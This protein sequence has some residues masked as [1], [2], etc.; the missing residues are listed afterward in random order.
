MYVVPVLEPLSA[1]GFFSVSRRLEVY[2]VIVFDYID[3]SGEYAQIV[4]DEEKLHRELEILTANM[5]G[6]LDEEEVV[7]NGERVRPRVLS[8]DVGFRG[9]PEEV[10]IAFFIYF[11]GK[12]VKGENYYENIYEE[13]V[14]EYPISAYWLFPPGSRVKS[15]EMSG[16]VALLAPNIV[17][18]KLEE[19][20]RVQGYERI[21]FTL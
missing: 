4:E 3:A 6:F 2:Q 20:E 21:V 1:I 13:E 16:D 19:G 12:P 5:Q 8:V 11:K 18:V 14:T 10:Y 15:V 7:I 9:T 17:A